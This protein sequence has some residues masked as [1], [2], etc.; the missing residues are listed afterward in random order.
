MLVGGETLNVFKVLLICA[1]L[2][3]AL[4]VGC[5]GPGEKGTGE[6]ESGNGTEIPPALRPASQST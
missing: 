1:L 5:G 4:L 3:G 2:F 6:E